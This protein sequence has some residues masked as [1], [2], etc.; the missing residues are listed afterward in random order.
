M[1]IKNPNFQK[2]EAENTIDNTD[3][4]SNSSEEKKA[5]EPCSKKGLLSMA[6]G[7][8]SQRDLQQS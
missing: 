5:E 3:E 7:G 6:T 2:S 4:K 8:S 1:G